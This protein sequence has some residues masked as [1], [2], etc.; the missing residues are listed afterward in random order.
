[1]QTLQAAVWA[2]PA[3]QARDSVTREPW[4]EMVTSM[5]AAARQLGQLGKATVFKVWDKRDRTTFMRAAGRR[6]TI[7]QL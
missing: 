7:K 5:P 3:Y 1:M 6:Y 4:Q 2:R